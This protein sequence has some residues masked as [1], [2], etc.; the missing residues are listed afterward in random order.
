LHAIKQLRCGFTLYDSTIGPIIGGAG[1]VPTTYRR[2]HSSQ[3]NAV[4][5]GNV[6]LSVEDLWSLDALG[7]TLNDGSVTDDQHAMNQFD[8]SIQRL[9]NGRYSV[10]WPWKTTQPDLSINFGLCVGRLQSLLRTLSANPEQRINYQKLIQQQL[11]SSIIER[12][13]LQPSVPQI[14]YIPHQ[15]VWNEQK[16]KLR[17][18]YD[19]SSSDYLRP[20]AQLALSMKEN[21]EMEAEFNP[22]PPSTRQQ[23]LDEWRKSE[24]YRNKFWIIWSRE[25]LQLL[26]EREQQLHK[27]PYAQERRTPRIG[28]VVLLNE[29]NRPRC[30]W[31]L[32]RIVE[33]PEGSGHAIRTA[34]IKLATGRTLVRSIAHLYPLEVTLTDTIAN[35]STPTSKKTQF[36]TSLPDPNIQQS[37]DEDEEPD[38]HSAITSEP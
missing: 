24:E 27:G 22:H 12:A 11:D 14:H 8:S 18:V 28:E 13:P 5:V 16:R 4:L 17:I 1:R 7:I 23:F 32:A 19:A 38:N 26:R 35:N 3:V 34:R 15:A 21:A 2:K 33:T 30:M 25:Y 36:V 20:R 31:R 6:T 10:F 29:Q 9:P 37:D